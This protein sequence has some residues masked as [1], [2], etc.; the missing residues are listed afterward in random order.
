MK[1]SG[2]SGA[3]SQGFDTIGEVMMHPTENSPAHE[4]APHNGAGYDAPAVAPNT[5]PDAASAL[6]ENWHDEEIE[7][8]GPISSLLIDAFASQSPPHT[9]NGLADEVTA[10]IESGRDLVRDDDV[11]LALYLLYG[12]YYGRV[13]ENGDQWEWHVDTIAA[14]LELERAFE[15]QLRRLVPTPELPNAAAEDVAKA[16]FALTAPDPD[17]GPSLSRH[18][19]KSLTREQAVE[20][21]VQRSVYTLK[22]ADPHSWAIPR[23]TGRAKAALVEIQADE[24]GNGRRERMHSEL[25]ARSMRGIGL[26]SRYG[27]YVNFAPAI[28]LAS[29]NMISLFGMNRRLRGAIAGHLAA[30][31]M[32]SS[33][34][35]GLYA[36]GFRRLGFGKNV[37]E[38]FDEHVEADAVHEQ[39]AARDLAGGLAESEP[40]LLSEIFFGAR[41]CLLIDDW[42]GEHILES[43]MAGESSLRKPFPFD[44]VLTGRGDDP[45][46]SASITSAGAG[47]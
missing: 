2:Q 21:M 40:A 39:I 20:F 19:A 43:W 47:R 31:E 23:L 10:A 8:R 1:L 44:A 13:V 34:P 11:Q 12:L 45:A 16:L 38:Y 5:I 35:N 15:G 18:V 6:C 41:A 26:D 7:P 14:R 33:I 46:S 24:Y 4:T 3:R 30:F 9:I 22:E 25:F 28:T 17:A 29:F 36:R 37:T 27:T 32:T 42:V